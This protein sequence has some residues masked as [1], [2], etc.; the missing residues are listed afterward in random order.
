MASFFSTFS[1]AAEMNRAINSGDFFIPKNANANA[2]FFDGLGNKFT[3]NLDYERELELLTREQRFN[4]AQAALTRN[5]NAEEAQKNRDFQERMANTAYQ[6]AY[7]DLKQAGLN[8]YLAY[9]QGGSATP[10]GS[11]LGGSTAS[12]GGHHSGRSGS[13]FDLLFGLLKTGIS[14]G[15]NTAFGVSQMSNSMQIAKLNNQTK[16]AIAEMYNDSRMSYYDYLA[17]LAQERHR[18]WY[19]YQHR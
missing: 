11:V 15:V 7:A 18:D 4:S 1:S 5:F 17:T 10:S 16:Y 13:G 3:G 8:P 2:D 14:L 6:R 12:V 9:T 19:R